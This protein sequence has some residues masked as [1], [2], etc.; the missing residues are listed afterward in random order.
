MSAGINHLCQLYPPCV[1]V[2]NLVV[3]PS[4]PR[5]RRLLHWCVLLSLPEP[6]VSRSGN[7]ITPCGGRKTE[8]A[9]GTRHAPEKKIEEP[10]STI[11]EGKGTPQDRRTNEP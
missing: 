2:E 9:P 11:Q 6:A 4:R 3:S 7:I 10:W 1:A 8:E 5:L